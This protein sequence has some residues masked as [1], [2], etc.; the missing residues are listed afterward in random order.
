MITHQIHVLQENFV[1]TIQVRIKI[2]KKGCYLRQQVTSGLPKISSENHLV[3]N[4]L[5]D[6]QILQ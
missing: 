1:S 5:T 2:K 4:L 6:I 3:V